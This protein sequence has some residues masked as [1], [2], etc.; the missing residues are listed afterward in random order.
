MNTLVQEQPDDLDVSR[1]PDGFVCLRWQY[2]GNK[3]TSIRI[4][5][6]AIDGGKVGE[7]PLQTSASC[8]SV[9]ADGHAPL[10]GNQQ[11]TT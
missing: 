8:V 1:C 5:V 2:Q 6:S 9:S 11:Q 3:L 10:P 7:R 4:L